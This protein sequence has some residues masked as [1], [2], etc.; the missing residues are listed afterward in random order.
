VSVLK[1]FHLRPLRRR[2][3]MQSETEAEIQVA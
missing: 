2:L 1:I 3:I